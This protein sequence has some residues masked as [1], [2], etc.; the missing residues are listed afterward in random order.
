[1]ASEQNNHPILPGRYYTIKCA[2]CG[3][4]WEAYRLDDPP[5][6]PF[7]CSLNCAIQALN[8]LGAGMKKTNTQLELPL[9]RS[10]AAE[11]K[12]LVHDRLHGFEHRQRA[13]EEK[14]MA[15]YARRKA[16]RDSVEAW[17]DSVKETG[18][19]LSLPFVR[20]VEV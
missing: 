13:R 14:R 10:L 16:R 1:M 2:N 7:Y 6:T 9:P 5:A 17:N 3:N 4:S 11:R 20:D 15:S 19:Q 18:A 12:A 8:L